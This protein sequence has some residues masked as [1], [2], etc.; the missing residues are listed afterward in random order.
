MG[1]QSTSR[2]TVVPLGSCNATGCSPSSSRMFCRSLFSLY[3]LSWFSSLSLL[4]FGL[5]MWV[6][7]C[8]YAISDMSHWF[9]VA[10]LFPV[11][12][13]VN[14]TCRV[15]W[16]AS[17]EATW[18]VTKLAH[19]CSYGCCWQVV[20]VASMR[21]FACYVFEL[22]PQQQKRVMTAVASGQCFSVDCSHC[23]HRMCVN[24]SIALRS[25]RNGSRAQS[26]L[27]VLLWAM[28]YGCCCHW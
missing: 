17:P 10:Q 13:A 7:V 24:L 20:Q 21:H 12:A 19:W 27:F 15:K 23:L 25:S 2:V 28:Q 9:I 5:L 26:R 8:Y 14:F 1:Y 16:V 4:W 22:N 3:L 6:P 11:P 18:Q